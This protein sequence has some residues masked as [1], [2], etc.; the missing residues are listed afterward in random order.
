[1]RKYNT[2]EVKIY[3]MNNNTE[4]QTEELRDK[5]SSFL[6][7]NF[8]QIKMHGGS[9]TILDVKPEDNYT[10][11][12]LTGSC[13]GCGISPMTTQAIKSRLPKNIDQIDSVDVQTGFE[14]E[15][16]RSDDVPF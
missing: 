6:L 9:F 8:P 7:R 11:I 3:S 13:S 2:Y 5:I 10:E 12:Q 14:T 1:M 4:D 16:T 15:P